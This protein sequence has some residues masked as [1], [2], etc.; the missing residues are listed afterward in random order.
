MRLFKDE[1]GATAV[2]VAMSLFMIMGFAALAIDSGIGFNER[3]QDQ[4]AADSAV[5]AGAQ[6]GGLG[7]DAIVAS[8]VDYANRNLENDV[9]TL[10]DWAS[11][12]DPDLLSFPPLEFTPIIASGVTYQCISSA[13]GTHLRVKLPTTSVETTFGK[14]LGV[15]EIQTGA[16]AIALITPVAGGG[17]RPFGLTSSAGPGSNC[18]VTAPAPLTAPPC[19]G[20]QTGNFFVID[21]PFIGAD[22]D[23]GTTRTCNGA[24]Q[25]R[26][27]TNVAQGLDHSVFEHWT[28]PPA[29]LVERDLLPDECDIGFPTQLYAQPGA[30]FALDPGLIGPGTYGGGFSSLLRQ[31]PG[32]FRDV[33]DGPATMPLDDRP[34]WDF[35]ATGGAACDA[36]N[37]GPAVL[38]E[39]RPAAMDLCLTTGNPTFSGNPATGIATS[40]RLIWVPKFEEPGWPPGG[41]LMTIESFQPAFI[42]TLYFNCNAGVCDLVFYP[43]DLTPPA[44][45]CDTNGAGCKMVNLRQLTSFVL[46]RGMLPSNAIPNNGGPG[47]TLFVG[48][49]ELWR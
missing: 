39:D 20:P 13:E 10:A 7:D 34:L 40:P 36:A 21:S 3:R 45:M 1:R 49:T 14:V 37:F 48:E 41:G 6:S 35:I 15:T 42:D 18:L 32:P 2:F 5:M 12:T 26:Y 24:N 8:V 19:T 9:F 23:F 46:N 30:G 43:G 11:C 4:A 16:E 44:E 33:R 28:Q 47:G 38:P 31:G 27:S 22:E 17:V 29:P 25:L